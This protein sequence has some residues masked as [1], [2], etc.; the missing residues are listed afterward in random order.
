MV[1]VLLHLC[2]YVV[3][4]GEVG[5]LEDEICKVDVGGV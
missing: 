1:D 5:E 3:E 2:V 4:D